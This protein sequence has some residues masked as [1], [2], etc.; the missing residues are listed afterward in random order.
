M[1]VAP[2]Q[3]TEQSGVLQLMLPTD[4]PARITLDPQ[5]REMM[6]DALARFLDAL[7][8]RD[9][10][11]GIAEIRHELATGTPFE[12]ATVGCVG[13]PARAAEVNDF[14]TYFN[15]RRIAPDHPAQALLVG[16]LH[17]SA[18]AFDLAARDT[19]MPRAL[20]AH[21]AKGFAAYARL[22]GRICGIDGLS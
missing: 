5:G 8:G 17:T 4:L 20:L 12:I 13:I 3:P 9:P 1:T 21:Q 16:L 14:D 11:A 18:A 10:A 15:V 7:Q 19:R 2:A 22:L 6:R